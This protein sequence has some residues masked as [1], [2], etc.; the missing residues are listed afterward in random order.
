MYYNEEIIK[1]G[2]D[3]ILCCVDYIDIED[4]QPL[5]YADIFFAVKDKL[6]DLI[7]EYI[8]N[9][10]E[11]GQNAYANLSLLLEDYLQIQPNTYS[12]E[13]AV[14]N[15]M[16]SPQMASYLDSKKVEINII[17]KKSL[18]PTYLLNRIDY[19]KA[20]FKSNMMSNLDCGLEGFLQ[21]LSQINK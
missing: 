20:D 4:N 10:N 16:D 9:S 12:L 7:E 2:N 6:I 21:V 13:V 14:E 11:S 1:D 17:S 5:K 19:K 3:A 18:I 8:V 15:I